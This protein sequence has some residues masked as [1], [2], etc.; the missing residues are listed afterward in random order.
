MIHRYGHIRIPEAGESCRGIG[1]SQRPAAGYAGRGKRCE[2][3]T[4]S[5]RSGTN[6]LLTLLSLH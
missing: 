5:F 4:S 3:S 2:N 1:L 6:E